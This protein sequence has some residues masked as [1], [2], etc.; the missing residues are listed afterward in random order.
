MDNIISESSDVMINN[1]NL[2]LDY[3]KQVNTS[4]IEDK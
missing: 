4:L 3:P 2:T 1:L